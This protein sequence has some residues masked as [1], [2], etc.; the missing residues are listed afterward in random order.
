MKFQ[1]RFRFNKS[2]S[3]HLFV[4]ILIDPVLMI[5]TLFTL[6]IY[7][8]GKL[9]SPYIVLSVILFALSFPGAWVTTKKI[10]QDAINTANQWVLIVGLLLFFGYATGYLYQF[11]HRV[12]SMWV[13]VTPLVL[14]IS[15]FFVNWYFSSVHYLSK[16]KKTAVI[17]GFNELG[18]QLEEKLNENTELAIEFKGYFD[19]FSVLDNAELSSSHSLLGSIEQLPAYVKKYSIE[20]IYIALPPSL[21]DEI[22]M[23]LDD[24]KD[25]TSSIYFVPNFFIADL[26]QARIDEIGGMPI[27]AVCETPFSGFNGL[28]K[29]VSDLLIASFVVCLILPVLF[30]LAC[31]VKLSSPGPIIFKQRRYGLDGEE[32]VVYKFRSMTV[33]ED[34]GIVK[35]ATKDDKR[36]TKFGQFIR[37]T[38][39]DELPQFINVLQG[40][41]SIVG[42]RPHAVSHN[43]MYR[44][45]IKGYM[46]RHKVKPGITG[47][48]QVNG[49]RGE[50]ASVASMKSR[51]DYDI[52]YLKTWSLALDVKI[53]LLTVTLIFKDSQAY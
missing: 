48:A 43:E 35:Q 51:I 45:L 24:L 12:I 47:W 41:M 46:V 38:S 27:V 9:T 39:L 2:L 8:E 36:V 16:V 1:Q 17:V 34:S 7:F 20:V 28:I 29:R 42:P 40:R 6:V 22:I 19:V 25:T 4:K 33:T 11:S 15:H 3:L 37:K 26:I 18:K 10:R 30:L 13:L 32:I 21:H 31:G 5:S 52:E 44:K 14:I 23:L 49:F 50:T 53:V